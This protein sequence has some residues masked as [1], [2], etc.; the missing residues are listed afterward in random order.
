MALTEI[1]RSPEHDLGPDRRRFVATFVTTTSAIA[2]DM[3]TYGAAYSGDSATAEPL[4]AHVHRIRIQ[5]N[6]LPGLA[7]FDVEYVGLRGQ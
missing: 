7:R 2:D 4:K 5:E 6:W 1:Y 3:P